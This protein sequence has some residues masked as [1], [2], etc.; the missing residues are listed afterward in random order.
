MEEN[1][2][3]KD[4]AGKNGFTWWVGIVEDRKDPLKLGRCRVRCVGWH[5]DDKMRLPTDALPWATPAYPVN[6]TN[7]YA[8]REGDMVLGFFV[9]GENAQEPVMLGAFPSIPLKAPNI[10]DPYTDPRTEEELKAAPRPPASKTYNKDGSGIAI[11]EKE[12]ADNYPNI[13]DEPSTSRIARNDEESIANTFIQERKTNV[14]AG[15]PTVNSNWSEPT[16]KYNAKYPYN[17]VMETESGHVLE[18]DDTP[19]AERIHQAHRNGSFEEWFP[20]G[21]KVEKITKDNYQIVMK[22]DHV[23][24]MGKCNI[25]IQGDAEVYVQKNAFVKVDGNYDM[26]VGG[27]CKVESGGNMSFTAPRIDLN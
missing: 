9:D 22:D 4:F 17:N 6:Q 16:T 3:K 20:D 2:D 27:T 18:F 11:T 8:P 13:L 10:Q 21:D 1:E 5:A 14:V 7:T 25:T 15:V 26:K 12:R 23:Y 24:I 19:G